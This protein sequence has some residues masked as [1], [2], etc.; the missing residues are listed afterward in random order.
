MRKRAPGRFAGKSDPALLALGFA[1]AFRRRAVA[2]EVADLLR[3]SD[4]LRVTTLRSETDQEEWERISPGPS[5]P[6]K[7]GLARGAQDHQSGV[8]A[9]AQGK[10]TAA[11]TTHG[12]L[13][14]Q[15]RG[16]PPPAG[17]FRR[18]QLSGGP[19]HGRHA[20]RGAGPVVEIHNVS[21]HESVDI[22]AVTSNQPSS[23]TIIPAQR[24]S[25][26]RAMCA[27]DP[28][29][30]DATD[31]VCF[32]SDQPD[33]GERVVVIYIL[34]RRRRD[35]HRCTSD[36]EIIISDHPISQARKAVRTTPSR[37]TAGSR[38]PR[39]P[40]HRATSSRQPFRHPHLCRIAVPT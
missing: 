1:G 26:V 22:P 33:R 7:P 5:R 39:L 14:H 23:L 25:D 40:P 29:L 31:P 10:P 30:R 2:R 6:S 28:S 19:D 37:E 13:G 3:V 15:G 17:A 24:F 21:R 4:G 27:L 34:A 9:G 16:A 36:A 12:P 35:A 8:P 11:G 32:G 18:P 20:G 38:R